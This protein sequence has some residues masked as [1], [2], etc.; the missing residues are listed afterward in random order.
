MKRLNFFILFIFFAAPLFGE[1]QTAR[2]PRLTLPQ[3]ETLLLQ[4]NL[5][6][7]ANRY[8]LDASEALLRISGFKPNPV[9]QLGAEQIPFHS[10]IPGSVPR[11]FTTNPDAGANPVYTFQFNKV[12]ERG[13][14]REIRIEQAAASGRAHDHRCQRQ[15]ERGEAQRAFG[16]DSRQL[17]TRNRRLAREASLVMSAWP[18]SQAR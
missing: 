7:A 12:I 16:V 15:Q 10:N 9:V 17:R 5:L 18:L 14:K 8:Q 1:P 13:H 6:I 2:P 3:A 11:F 4:R